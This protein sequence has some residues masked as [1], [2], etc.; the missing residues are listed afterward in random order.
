MA[1]DHDTS[2]FLIDPWQ[3]EP[4]RL[5][6][7]DFA[8]GTFDDGSPESLFA[9]D[10]SHSGEAASVFS[11]LIASP[12]ASY[13][14]EI[15]QPGVSGNS[16]GDWKVYRALVAMVW[17]KVAGDSRSG[18]DVPPDEPFTLDRLCAQ[19]DKL[20]DLIGKKSVERYPLIGVPLPPSAAPLFFS[21]AGY[22]TIPLVGTPPI[23]A[24]PLTPRHFIAT[25]EKGFSADGL[26]QWLSHPIALSAF[27]LGIGPAGRAVI[28]PELVET[29]K[30]NPLGFQRTLHE[31]RKNAEDL[32]EMVRESDRLVTSTSR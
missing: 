27:S 17:L 4:R 20:L 25:P 22:F 13:R 5:H 3:I 15:V 11:A 9:G 23:V 8:T 16:S 32:F 29:K 10:G 28:P 1:D 24:V 19:Q 30:A 7:Y 2:R 18:I 14:T 31:Q 21:E 26:T 6:H 12:V